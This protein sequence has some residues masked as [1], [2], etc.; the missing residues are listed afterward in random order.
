MAKKDQVQ[1]TIELWRAIH[2]GCWPGPPQDIRI[3]EAANEVM[4]GLALLNLAN[5][6]ANPAVAKQVKR[7]ATESLSKSLPALQK[8]VGA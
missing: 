6:F 4:S 2:G 3:S 1:Q 7:V 5:A 8:Q